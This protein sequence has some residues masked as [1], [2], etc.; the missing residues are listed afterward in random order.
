MS[1]PF[2]RSGAG[3]ALP[4]EAEALQ[5]RYARRVANDPRYSVFHP[6]ALW[7][8]QERQRA[9]LALLARH[10]WRDLSECRMLEV[11]SGTGDNLL[12]WLRW[13]AQPG[14]LAGIE[15][16]P[17]RHQQ[18]RERL[19]LSV[20]LVHGDACEVLEAQACD[21]AAAGFDIIL[22]ATVFSSLLNDAVQQRLAQ[23]MWARLKPGGAILWYDF[24]VD[25]PRNPDV[26]GVPLARVCDLFARAH[27]SAQ[28]LTLAPPLARLLARCHPALQGLFNWPWLRTHRLV[29]L[30]KPHP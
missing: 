12:D 26:R 10:G 27:V 21:P 28:R 5:T 3:Q 19:P 15:L 11:G 1:D 16:L 13:G 25:N 9:T 17:E 7:A 23:A 14:H 22:Q 6:T 18:A 8:W 24:T 29:W 4:S 2:P 20:S 30:A